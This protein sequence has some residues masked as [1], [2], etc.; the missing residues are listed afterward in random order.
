MNSRCQATASLCAARRPCRLCKPVYDA[1]ASTLR[2][3]PERKS[4]DL[5]GRTEDVPPRSAMS[6][7]RSGRAKRKGGVRCT[8]CVNI[9]RP[10]L[11][12]RSVPTRG[13]PD[14]HRVRA[15]Y[16]RPIPHDPIRIDN[17]AQS[18]ARCYDPSCRNVSTFRR[19]A[20]VVVER[21]MVPARPKPVN[22]RS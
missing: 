2:A 21:N 8:G 11:N 9:V 5:A 15:S 18:P 6:G 12:P 10:G 4:L 1:R 13:V 17:S 7:G 3:G 16:A 14:P 20:D 22:I 19:W